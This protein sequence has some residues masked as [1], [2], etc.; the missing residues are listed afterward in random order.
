MVITAFEPEVTTSRAI[1]QPNSHTV[2]KHFSYGNMAIKV[3]VVITKIIPKGWRIADPERG[4]KQPDDS[5]T[6]FPDIPVQC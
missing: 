2:G 6:D 5:K 4:R 3:P 1:V